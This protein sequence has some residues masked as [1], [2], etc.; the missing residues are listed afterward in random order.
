MARLKG[1]F[2]KLKGSV[3]D[4]TFKQKSGKTIVSEKITQ[5]ND[6]KTTGQLKQR[7]KWTN[8]IRLYQVLVGY[9]KLAFGGTRNGRSDYNKFVSANLTKVPIYLTKED[10]SAGT[11]L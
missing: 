2:S 10:A 9:M 1:A 4:F 5:S 11:S 3:G 7:M 8:V 6:A